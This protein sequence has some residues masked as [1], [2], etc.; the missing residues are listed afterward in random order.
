M[1]IEIP[2]S[3]VPVNS[4]T[5]ADELG[6]LIGIDRLS[7]EAAGDY[8]DR[9]AMAVTSSRSADYIGLMNQI[10]LALDLPMSQAI[11]IDGPDDATITVS[12]GGLSLSAARAVTTIP[13]VSLTVDNFW[14]WQTLSALVAAV[15]QVPGFSATLLGDDGL[16]LQLVHQSN[17]NQILAEAISGQTTRLTYGALVQGSELF[18]IPVPAYS[19]G[20]DGQTLRFTSPLTYGCQVTYNYRLLPYRLVAAPVGL[21]SLSDPELTGIAL[22]SNGT[23]VYQLREYLWQAAAKDLSYWGK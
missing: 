13:L 16:A 10:C 12:I 11:E 7:G 14:K 6:V 23:M 8:L 22:G 5:Y 3:Q 9:L 17:T 18:S 15:N 1:T 2:A 20:A 21:I 4:S 19:Y